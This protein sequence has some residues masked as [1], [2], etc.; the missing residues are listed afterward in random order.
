MLLLKWPDEANANISYI[1]TIK[2][3][4]TNGNVNFGVLYDRGIQGFKNIM[5]PVGGGYHSRLAI[6]LANDITMQEK[7][8]TDYFRILPLEENE[9]ESQDQIAYLQ[10]VVMTEL[11]QI[12]NNASLRVIHNDFVA[13]AII[14][15][16]HANEYDLIIIGSSEEADNEGFIFGRLVDQITEK[17]ACSVLVIRQHESP[18]ASWLSHQIKRF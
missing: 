1:D 12:P 7:G 15:E 6:H 18:A 16:S 4:I 17:A 13:E 9:E 3:V 11:G 5:V 10:E 14:E 8:I 2:K